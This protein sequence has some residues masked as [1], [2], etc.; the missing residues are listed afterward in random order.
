MKHV[1]LSMKWLDSGME[2]DRNLLQCVRFDM[3]F[4]MSIFWTGK[5]T[6]VTAKQLSKPRGVFCLFD[7][8]VF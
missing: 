4:S 1:R 3:H 2:N 6:F 7:V 8:I 5:V